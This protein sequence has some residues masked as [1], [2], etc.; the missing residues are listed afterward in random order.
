VVVFVSL[1]IIGIVSLLDPE[2]PI[3]FRRLTEF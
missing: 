1:A 3:W 2:A